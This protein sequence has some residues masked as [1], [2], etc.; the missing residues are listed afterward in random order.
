MPP[1]NDHANGQ[2]EL[3]LSGLSDGER[4]SLCEA[5]DRVLNTGAVVAGEVTISVAGVDLVYLGL[6]LVL[7]SVETARGRGALGLT[8][9]LGKEACGGV[10]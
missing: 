3:Q 9:E 4:V 10:S 5:L 8:L 1:Y 6:Q 2:A 7:S